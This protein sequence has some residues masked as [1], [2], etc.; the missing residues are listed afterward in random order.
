MADG[1]QVQVLADVFFF[2]RRRAETSERKA[3]R[4]EIAILAAGRP[5]FMILYIARAE[6][7]IKKP[8]SPDGRRNVPTIY[9][10]LLLMPGMRS[11][12]S[13]ER[14]EGRQQGR[15]AEKCLK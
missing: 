14:E 12:D 10:R 7:Q 9:V 13:I 11:K 1:G 4:Y 3:D 5:L 8:L 6:E 15:P 2:D